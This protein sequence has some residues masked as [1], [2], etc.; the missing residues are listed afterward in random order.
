MG[1]NLRVGDYIY[2]NMLVHRKVPS[3]RF[4]GSEASR[5]ALWQAIEN[6]AFR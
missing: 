5:E 1:V 4:G 2:Q 3:A 6:P